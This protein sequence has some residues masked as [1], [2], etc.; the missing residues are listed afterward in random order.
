[1]YDQIRK[2]DILFIPNDDSKVGYKCVVQKNAKDSVISVVLDY[3][4]DFMSPY[5]NYKDCIKFGDKISSDGMPFRYFCYLKRGIGYVGVTF[6]DDPILWLE[7]LYIE[8]PV[9]QK[10]WQNT[11]A[12]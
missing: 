11:E 1:M 9:K 3:H 4:A 8:K 12:A 2:K 10:E 6:Y 7:G 5:C